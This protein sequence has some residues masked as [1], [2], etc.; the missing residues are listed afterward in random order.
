MDLKI[1]LGIDYTDPSNQT[2]TYTVSMMSS[3]GGQPLNSST[4]SHVVFTESNASG[5]QDGRKVGSIPSI[6]DERYEE[7][8]FYS[9]TEFNFEDT[10]LGSRM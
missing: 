2:F 1:N 5:C 7:D 8:I 9:V 6:T 10:P 3:P 4:K